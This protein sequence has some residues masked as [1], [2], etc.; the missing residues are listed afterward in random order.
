[1]LSLRLDGSVKRILEDVFRGIPQ[2]LLICL[3][4]FGVPTVDINVLPTAQSPVSAYEC[5]RHGHPRT[6]SGADGR[7]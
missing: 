1:V 7:Q 4:G 6:S 5:A 3:P 2:I